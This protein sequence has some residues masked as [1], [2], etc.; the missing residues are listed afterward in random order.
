[1]MAALAVVIASA[2]SFIAKFLVSLI[3]LVTNIAFYG[4]FSLSHAGPE[5]LIGVV[6]NR[7]TSHWGNRCWPYGSLWLESYP[8]PWY[9]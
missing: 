8:W 7:Y 3:D 9:T 1:M 6:G 5:Q 2:V 4:T